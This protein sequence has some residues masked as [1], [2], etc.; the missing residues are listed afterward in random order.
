M[1][2]LGKSGPLILASLGG[3]E[4][5]SLTLLYLLHFVEYDFMRKLV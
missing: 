3:K 5:P 2:R 4:I 1:A